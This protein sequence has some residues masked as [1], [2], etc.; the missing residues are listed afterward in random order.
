MTKFWI[1][2]IILLL[3]Y[4]AAALLFWRIPRLAKKQ[5]EGNIRVSVLIP[6]RN[7]AKTLPLLLA[8]L[9]AQSFTPHE[10]IVANDDSTD[11]TNEIARSFGVTL[12]DLNEKPAD[13]IGKSWACQQAA[14]AAH[15]DVFLFLDADVR[16]CPDGLERIVAGY[17]AFGTISVQPYHATQKAYEQFAM[18]FNIIHLGA[19]GSALPR[20]FHLGLFGPVI[21]ISREDYRRIGG[22]AGVKSAIVEDM[23]LAASLRRNNIPFSVFLGDAGVS[24]R[25]YPAGFRALWQGFSK[26]LSTGAA[27]TPLWL[28]LLVGL[29]FASV[30]S[31][32][33]HLILALVNAEALALLYGALYAIWVIVLFFISRRIGRF[34]PFAVLLYPLQ[35]I[36]F[37][38]IFINSMV[39]RFVLKRVFWKGRAIKLE[40]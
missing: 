15:G 36:L 35:L 22:H 29:M 30:A 32:A 20:P 13:W 10:I 24:F 9:R 31:A 34:S 19:N 14:A 27:K 33:L 8:D 40:R 1:E 26:N 38:L 11:E 7:E 6:A 37:L 3:G 4:G 28:F 18:I 5:V 17:E 23:A 25:M 39:L 12:L 16:L 2:L 21:A